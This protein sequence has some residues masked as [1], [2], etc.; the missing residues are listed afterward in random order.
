MRISDWSSDVCS[1]DLERQSTG[2]HADA[3]VGIVDDRAVIGVEGRLAGHAG[4]AVVVDMDIAET[5]A[6]ADVEV[7]HPRG[8]GRA[9]I[10]A[11]DFGD[12]GIVDAVEAEERPARVDART[13][14]E[15]AG[16]EAQE[17]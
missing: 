6:G 5:V 7:S 10:G 15:R 16:A 11:V 9:D 8:N 14:R 17:V 12:L 1:S 2:A 3:G 13:R 4:Q